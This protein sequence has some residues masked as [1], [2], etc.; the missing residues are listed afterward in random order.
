VQA[1]RVPNQRQLASGT[2]F[3]TF[4]SCLLPFA[5][6]L[7]FSTPVGAELVRL[8]NGR[9]IS[10]DSCRF[11]GDQVILILRN[12]G[13]IRTAR[14][15]V[16]ELMPDEVPYAQAVA[17]EALAMSAAAA[18]PR[19]SLDSIYDQIDRLAE[20]FG[21][22]TRLAH[23]VVRA[24]SNYNPLAISPKGAMGLMQIMPVVVRQYGIEDPFNT[25]QNLEAGLR[26]LRVL[27]DRFGLTRGLAAYNAGEAAVVRFGA[28]PPYRETQ[29]YVQRVLAL[30]RKL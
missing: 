17:I 6:A 30:Y 14:S 28:V 10:V 7:S 12:G 18:G 26:H 9:V 23:A 27:I 1:T 11:E 15:I 16:A 5:L 21:V 13:Q 19:P 29:T 4:A 24:E 20:R 2:A 22:P 8:T 3:R 25:R